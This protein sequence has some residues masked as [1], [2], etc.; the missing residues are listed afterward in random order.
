MATLATANASGQEGGKLPVRKALRPSPRC[1]GV[2]LVSHDSHPGSSGEEG[3]NLSVRLSV[4]LTTWQWPRS[5]RYLHS[6]K[7]PAQDFVRCPRAE[8]VSVLRHCVPSLSMA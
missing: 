3:Q 2:Q 5:L 1:M 7:A 4:C 8:A 6:P